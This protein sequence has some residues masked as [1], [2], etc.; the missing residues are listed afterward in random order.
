MYRRLT[1]G[2]SDVL[3]MAAA[4]QTRDA[5]AADFG[6]GVASVYRIL[7]E[8]RASDADPDFSTNIRDGL[9]IPH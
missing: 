1:P 3:R 6:I 2:P 5:I 7:A 4:G 9:L 8:A